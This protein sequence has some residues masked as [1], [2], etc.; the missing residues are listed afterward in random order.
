[1]AH[2]EVK[3]TLG[4]VIF[5]PLTEAV[6]D[7]P[8][9]PLLHLFFQSPGLTALYFQLSSM[10]SFVSFCF[11]DPF[12][13]ISLN[14]KTVCHF[15]GRKFPKVLF[16][17][18]FF[19]L[20]TYFPHRCPSPLRSSSICPPVLPSICPFFFI[21]FIILPFR[22]SINL[23]RRPSIHLSIF[24]FTGNKS[25]ALFYHRRRPLH[26]QAGRAAASRPRRALTRRVHC[27]TTQLQRRNLPPVPR[28]FQP[29]RRTFILGIF[30]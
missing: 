2:K 10:R 29:L 3:T 6:Q 11:S 17:L 7:S 12:F 27:A 30:L 5:P 26:P 13:L 25:A 20:T 21:P 23:S 18:L 19:S 14:P 8:L 4:F 28:P 22:P 9:F 15:T 24:L 1:M 16:F